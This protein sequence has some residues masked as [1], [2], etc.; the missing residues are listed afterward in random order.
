MGTPASTPTVGEAESGTWRGASPGGSSQQ[1]WPLT[2]SP[3]PP[4]HIPWF[5]RGWAVTHMGSSLRWAHLTGTGLTCP[6]SLRTLRLHTLLFISF[7][8]P[9]WWPAPTTPNPSLQYQTLEGPS[10][11]LWVIY[12]TATTTS[13]WSLP[14]F[15]TM[16]SILI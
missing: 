12:P 4:C 5:A 8:P 3:A 13:F 16:C 2:H 14:V 15:F 7:H 11:L 9:A 1:Q 10:G 6:Q